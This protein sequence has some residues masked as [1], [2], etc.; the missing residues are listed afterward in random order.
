MAFRI[1]LVFG[2]GIGLILT[3][4]GCDENIRI[5]AREATSNKCANC[6]GGCVFSNGVCYTDIGQDSCLT[7]AH[8]TWCPQPELPHPLAG[9]RR[10]QPQPAPTPPQP[11]IHGHGISSWFSQQEFDEFFPHINSAD[12]TGKNFFTYTALVEAARAFPTFAN[13]GD[14][15]KDKLELAAFLAQ[16][17]HET[18]GGWATAPGGAQ[19]WG[20]CFKEEVGCDSGRCTG[21]CQTSQKYPCV[22]G[23]TYHGRGPMQLSYN[24]NYGA[25]SND[26]FGNASKLLANPSLLTTDPVVAYKAGLWFWMTAQEPKPSCHAV[27]SGEWQPTAADVDLMRTAGYGMVTNIINGGLEC[28]KPTNEKVRD[29]VDFYKRYAGIL[30]VTVG[31]STLLYCDKMT[32]YR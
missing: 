12:C 1:E 4:Q 8:N 3:L 32:S 26:V 19:A 22:S 31:E 25:F 14:P 29:R 24:Y 23:Q 13:S 6:N 27:V 11:S 30:G 7:W 28:N 2:A 5:I 20:Y 16:T 17:S 9:A 10:P 21:Y 15:L 18:T